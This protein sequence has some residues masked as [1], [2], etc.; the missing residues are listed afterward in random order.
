MRAP[1]LLILAAALTGCMTGDGLQE[2]LRNASSGY[3]RALRWGDIDR[4]AEYL[5]SKSVNAFLETHDATSE[6]LVIV[7]YE[8]TR[9]DL[10]RELG[11]AA[12]RAQI[13]WHT[14]RQLIVKST[15]VDQLWQ[16]H[17]GDFVLVDERRAA[18]EPLAIF[19][20][21]EETP[22]PYL[23]G[24]EAYRTEHEIGKENK[25]SKRK[26]RR[27]RRKARNRQD[28]DDLTARSR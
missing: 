9:L 13:S 6:K 12:S 25:G 22:H 19:A 10:D 23:P 24:L 3:N 4:A 27:R 7:E 17:E 1:L 8:L 21:V 28:G 15:V 11:V 14:E 2:K 16:F 20:E 26:K 5:P 18:G